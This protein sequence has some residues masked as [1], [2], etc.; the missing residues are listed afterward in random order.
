VGNRKGAVEEVVIAGAQMIVRARVTDLALSFIVPSS[1]AIG[2]D[3]RNV[4]FYRKEISSRYL[5]RNG[6]DLMPS[7]VVDQDDMTFDGMGENG[8]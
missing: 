2:H 4:V 7:G 8:G 3:T 6:V 5:P 1:F